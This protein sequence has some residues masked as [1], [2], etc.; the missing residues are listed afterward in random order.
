M[1]I[2]PQLIDKALDAIPYPVGKSNLLKILRDYKANEQII[3]LVERLPDITFNSAQ[4]AKN[5]IKGLDTL[6]NLGG[7]GGFFNKK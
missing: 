6:K 2:D 1:N 7:L 4:D 5:A 3:N